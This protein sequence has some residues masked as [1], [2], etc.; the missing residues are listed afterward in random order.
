MHFISFFILLIILLTAS[1][2]WS[3]S[4]G[5]SQ[6][7]CCQCCISFVKD[8]GQD[9]LLCY[10]QTGYRQVRSKSVL[11]QQVRHSK[12]E[13]YPRK[14]VRGKSYKR[15]SSSYKKKIK[16]CKSDLRL[17]FNSIHT[18]T[19]V[20]PGILTE[21]ISAMHCGRCHIILMSA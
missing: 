10:P 7:R 9:A 19:D 14:R 1:P 15:S 2:A 6:L 20:C 4:A 5:K 13:S 21:S 8:E 12:E 16:N 11:S 17:F 18:A 3:S